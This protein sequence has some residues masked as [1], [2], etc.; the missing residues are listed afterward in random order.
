MCTKRTA[1]ADKLPDPK[2]HKRSPSNNKPVSIE[3]TTSFEPAWWGNVLVDRTQSTLVTKPAK[4][5]PTKTANYPPV[6]TLILGTHPSIASLSTNQFFGHQ[7]NA[8]WY[9]V[10]DAL[11]FRRNEAVSAST[12]KP[13]ATYYNHL[14]YDT[15]TI[16][17]YD[18]QLELFVSR[19]FALWDI[20]RECERK[21]SLDQDIN[22]ETPNLIREFCQDRGSVRRIVI[23][24]GTTGGIFFVKHFKEWFLDGGVV[25]GRDDMSQRCFKAVMNRAKKAAVAETDGDDKREAIEVV[26]LPS[27][28]PAAAKFTYLEKR[29]AWERWCFEPGLADYK[30]WAK[31]SYVHGDDDK[32]PKKE[33]KG[34]NAVS[35]SPA[36]TPAK[37]SV[38]KSPSTASTASSQKS[39]PNKAPAIQFASSDIA[40]LSPENDWIDLQVPPEELRP[41]ATLTNGQCFNWMVVDTENGDGDQSNAKQSAWGSHDATEWIGPLGDRVLSIRETPSSTLCRVLHGPLEGTTDD[42]RVS[43][44]F[45]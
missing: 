39:S 27:V 14:R 25:A 29:E 1:A 40:K 37:K 16:I 44:V 2:K 21:G 20:V 11:G 15:N 31:R 30:D 5:E 6:H 34:M 23:A 10:G 22:G 33:T 7:Q 12:K 18:D 42:L 38:P 28:S 36:K 19:G 24:N 32:S 45:N 17:E 8:F 35:P 4:N 3:R 26:C 9:L 13:Y 43:K 41:S